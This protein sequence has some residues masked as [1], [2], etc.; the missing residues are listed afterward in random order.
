MRGNEDQHS[1]L[2]CRVHYSGLACVCLVTALVVTAEHSDDVCKAM[3]HAYTSVVQDPVPRVGKF[4]VVYSRPGQRV[5]LDAGGEMQVRPS[6][7]DMRLS[8]INPGSSEKAFLFTCHS[9][10]NCGPASSIAA[11]FPPVAVLTDREVVAHAQWGL[12]TS[13][14]ECQGR[15]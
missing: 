5:V 4:G 3:N 1:H 14:S 8:S 9:V 11:A 7:L 2:L 12:E 10:L 6:P 13:A 15:A